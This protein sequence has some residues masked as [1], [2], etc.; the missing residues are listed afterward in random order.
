[1]M[2]YDASLLFSVYI[3]RSSSSAGIITAA[4]PSSFTTPMRSPFSTRSRRASKLSSHS[5]KV[6]TSIDLIFIS[7]PHPELPDQ[8]TQFDLHQD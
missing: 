4:V 7:I 5:F 8:H 3:R 1:M 2:N 6:K